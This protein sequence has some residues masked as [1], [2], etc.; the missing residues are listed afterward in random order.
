MN[1]GA[2]PALPDSLNGQNVLL[3]VLSL[4]QQCWR[5]MTYSQFGNLLSLIVTYL[6]QGKIS[7][8]HSWSSEDRSLVKCMLLQNLL[9][10]HVPQRMN[11]HVLL[12]LLLLVR[13]W[14]TF[15]PTIVKSSAGLDS[16][17]FAIVPLQKMI[18]EYPPCKHCIN[19]SNS[20]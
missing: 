20:N 17:G 19:Y 7:C 2:P 15:S 8:E 9:T 6:L 10:V 18:P 16:S 4:W 3:F 1:T 13:R 14:Y 5:M 12:I 11:S